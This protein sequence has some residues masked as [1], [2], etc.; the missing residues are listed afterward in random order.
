MMPPPWPALCTPCQIAK[1]WERTFAV[2][3][4]PS[5]E[6]VGQIHNRMPAILKPESYDRWLSLEP[7]P[8]DL[9]ITYPSE[10]MTMWPISIRVNKPEN[11]DPSILERVSEPMDWQAPWMGAPIWMRNPKDERLVSQ[12]RLNWCVGDPINWSE[13]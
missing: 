4:M 5:N 12:A 10:P 8:D 2:I 11:D 9:L 1:E 3:T 7:D 13:D 6:L